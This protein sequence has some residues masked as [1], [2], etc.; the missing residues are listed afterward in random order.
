MQQQGLEASWGYVFHKA[1]G[2]SSP[3]GGGSH[4]H[5]QRKQT[6]DSTSSMFREE[7]TCNMRFYIQLAFHYPIH[8]QP[9]CSADFKNSAHKF[10]C[11]QTCM[12]FQS[13]RENSKSACFKHLVLPSSSS[14]F[15]SPFPLHLLLSPSRHGGEGLVTSVTTVTFQS[16]S[17]TKPL[18]SAAE[19][20]VSFQFSVNCLS[21][22]RRT[23]RD[24]RGDSTLPSARP[25]RDARTV[26]RIPSATGSGAA[27]KRMRRARHT[28]PGRTVGAAMM[29]A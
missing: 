5:L 18:L 12:L 28:E 7:K 4:K 23:Q 15:L 13:I 29:A 22:E 8:P 10:A 1:Q 27:H 6:S 21:N 25:Y 16:Y 17:V 3:H 20:A 9:G 14:S 19:P 24:S 11:H 2:M 26:T